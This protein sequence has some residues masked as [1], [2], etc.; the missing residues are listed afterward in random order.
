MT[1]LD[2]RGQLY[3]STYLGG[4][5]YDIGRGI[6]VDQSAFAYVMGI[7][8]SGDFPTLNASQPTYGGGPWD[9]F[10]AKIRP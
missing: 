1:N 7:T 5:A 10:I 3:Y 2:S 4:S 8:S 9:V 6:A